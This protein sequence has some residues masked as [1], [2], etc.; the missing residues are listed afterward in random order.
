MHF[1]MFI[2][3]YNRCLKSYC[4]QVVKPLFLNSSSLETTLLANL[5]SQTTQ[6]RKI[7][8]KVSNA[9]GHPLLS[10]MPRVKPSSYTG[11]TLRILKTL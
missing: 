5:Y 3:A 8:R 4:F 10:V 11:L 1:T 7:F 6:D 2:H 9:K